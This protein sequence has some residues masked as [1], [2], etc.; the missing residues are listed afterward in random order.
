MELDKSKNSG[1]SP[2]G[3]Q[4]HTGGVDTTTD[5]PLLA[6]AEAGD[7]NMDLGTPGGIPA[8]YSEAP[9]SPRLHGFSERSPM[10]SVSPNFQASRTRQVFNRA[11]VTPTCQER[12]IGISSG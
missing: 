1:S 9:L 6:R 10:E 2:C 11:L 5:L 12:H 4:A 8:A 3:P 7:N